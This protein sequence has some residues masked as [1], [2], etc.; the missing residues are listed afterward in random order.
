MLNYQRI[1]HKP[2]LIRNFTGFTQEALTA[3]LPS[4][5]TAYDDH[6][7]TKDQHRQTSRQ[8]QQGGGR[9]PTLQTMADRLLFILFYFK[10]YPTQ[11][12][13]AFFFGFSQGQAN[14]WI[15]RLTPIL[16]QALGYEMQLPLRQPADIERILAQCPSLEFIID[17]TERPIQ[18]PKNN[19]RQR[20]YYSGKKK[21][22]TVKNIVITEKKTGKIKGLSPTVEGKKHDKAIVDEQNY[23]F[24]EDST[25]YQD[26]GFQGYEPEK[27]TIY[28]PKKKPKGKELTEEEKQR[29]RE[30]SSERISVEHSIRGVK[31]YHI[32]RDVYRNQIS[33]YDDLVM[34]TTCGLHNF[35]IHHRKAA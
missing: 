24:P 18:R 9:K 1:A 33:G 12:V 35:R 15:H 22:H 10:F 8:R 31:I 27:T 28:Q 7:H 16:N 4:F 20:Q 2:N 13:L 5:S 30:I 14:H 29:N 34:E 25:L 17:G 11:E 23:R 26:T 6:L 19:D 32:V 3:L 21:R